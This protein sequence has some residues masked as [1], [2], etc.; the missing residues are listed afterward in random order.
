MLLP[1]LI[2][3]GL[4]IVQGLFPAVFLGW[5]VSALRH[6]G[7]FALAGAFR[8]STLGGTLDASLVGLRVRDLFGA[9]INAAASPLLAFS[10]LVLALL[11]AGLLRRSAGSRERTAPTWLCGYQLLNEKNRFTD[12]GMFAAL[13]H[14]FRWTG[15]K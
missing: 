5:I 7:G 14:F 15:G 2:L 13:K 11:F 6:S 8:P 1:K 4:I 12:R 9:P 10:L 3:S